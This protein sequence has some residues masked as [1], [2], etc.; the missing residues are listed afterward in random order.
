MGECSPWLWLCLG[1]GGGSAASEPVAGSG[2]HSVG[3]ALQY[4]MFA[5]ERYRCLVLLGCGAH[6]F[7]S[8]KSHHPAVWDC[9]NKLS[10]LLLSC[11]VAEPREC[12]GFT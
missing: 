8:A 1:K 10:V 2:R 11:H 12:E 6:S 9:L 5:K 7:P 4:V 3:C